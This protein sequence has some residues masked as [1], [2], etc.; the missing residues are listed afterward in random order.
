V[1]KEIDELHRQISNKQEDAHEILIGLNRR[2]NEYADCVR[3]QHEAAAA[4][5]GGRKRQ[6]IRKSGKRKY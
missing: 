2:R 6:T 5:Q 4:N 3:R 1:N